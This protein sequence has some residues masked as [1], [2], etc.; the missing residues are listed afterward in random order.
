MYLPRFTTA[1]SIYNPMMP[2]SLLYHAMVT[3]GPAS[4]NDTR[5][6]GGRQLPMHVA[7][8]DLV[9]SGTSAAV[10]VVSTHN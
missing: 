8:M 3:S 4:R 7:Q 1:A 5:K 10:W 6:F 9:M 2:L